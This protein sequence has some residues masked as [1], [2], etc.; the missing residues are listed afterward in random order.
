M[1]VRL[2]PGDERAWS[3]LGYA[4]AKKGEVVEA[5]A[6]FRRAGQDALALELEHAA[7]VRRPPTPS[8]STRSRRIASTGWR[9]AASA[10]RRRV[11]PPA[12][13]AAAARRPRWART[14]WRRRCRRR[15]TS[16]AA[17][18]RRRPTC[19]R[20]VGRRGRRARSRRRRCRCWR[21]CC[22]A[23]G[24]R[25]RRR[26]RPGALRLTVADE[27]HVRAD[28][29]LAGAGNLAWQPGVPPVAGAPHD[30]AAG[31]ATARASSGSP[32]AGDVWIA[33]AARA[34]A[35]GVADRRRA[36]RARGSRAG[37]RRR[38]CR[39]RPAPC[40]GADLRML[41]FRGRGIGRARAR[42]RRRSR[43]R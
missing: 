14:R 2:T 43:S 12:P 29:V 5:A 40:P 13:A 24:R 1:A 15:S 41:Q 42:A 4:Y 38:R 9:M 21:S 20:T 25:R 16:A 32:G 18:R 34:L 6:A 39:G 11:T 35:A 7:T 31:R 23:S 26:S 28:G 30:R 8:L 22:R 36:L 27:A 10:P 33:G 37:V 3:Y 17:R 19:R